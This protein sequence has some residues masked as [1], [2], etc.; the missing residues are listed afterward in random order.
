MKQ[1]SLAL[2]LQVGKAHSVKL[3]VSSCKAHK[4]ILDFL[5]MKALPTPPETAEGLQVCSGLGLTIF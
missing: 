1:W 2:A 4:L 5:G 3:R